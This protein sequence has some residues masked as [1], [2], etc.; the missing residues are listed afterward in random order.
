MKFQELLKG[1]FQ[2]E[3]SDLDFGIY[4]I[5]NYKRDR[6]KKFIEDDLVTRVKNSFAKYEKEI[7]KNLDEQID[8]QKNII[9]KIS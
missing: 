1:L 3:T 6:I 9:T 4:R 7:D 8:K 5:L 2:F